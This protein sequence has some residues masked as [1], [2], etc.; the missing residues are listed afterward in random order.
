MLV[1]TVREITKWY[2]DLKVLDRVSFNLNPGSAR[3]LI[4]PNGQRQDHPA[5]HHHRE[6][7]PDRGTVH[8]SPASLRIGY[9]AQAL[10]FAEGATVAD[11][12]RAAE[13]EREAAEVRLARLA[14]ALAAAE[15][16]ALAV[17]LAEYDTA[18][19]EFQALGGGARY[20]DA[21]AVLA[22]LGM[23]DVSAG[24]GS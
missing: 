11:V 2:G 21:D 6:L 22:G 12:L 1:L 4:G 3:G 16:D 20:A 7:S 15:G 14:E 18:L 10:E 19:A 17:A 24:R 13:G 5:A 9:L 8:L 23:A